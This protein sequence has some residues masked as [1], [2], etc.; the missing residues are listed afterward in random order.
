MNETN[1][2]KLDNVALLLI[3]DPTFFKKAHIDFISSLK[4]YQSDLIQIYLIK[5]II[6]CERDHVLPFLLDNNNL[7]ND[8]LK[9]IFNE[10][11]ND[12]NLTEEKPNLEMNGNEVQILFGINIPGI[13][14]IYE[15]II[16]Y[17]DSLKEEFLLNEDIIRN[18][19]INNENFGVIKNNEDFD[20]IKNNYITQQNILINKIASEFQKNKLFYYL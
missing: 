8:I 11:F 14:Q 16:Q 10:Y 18:Y 15:T 20:I 13:K 12:L 2:Y 7:K 17:V 9:N 4:K 3:K 19:Q 1:W 6:K 5:I